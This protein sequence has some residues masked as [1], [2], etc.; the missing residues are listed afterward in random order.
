VG[1]L[2]AA[3][4]LVC[5]PGGVRWVFALATIPALVGWLIVQLAAREVPGLRIEPSAA[6]RSSLPREL[7]RRRLA[8]ICFLFS[9]RQR[10]A[11]PFPPA[12]RVS[13]PE[14]RR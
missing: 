7:S 4:V 10:G 1:P 9:P 6:A 2:L 13:G 3:L 8:A 5:M 14:S 11:T 12:A